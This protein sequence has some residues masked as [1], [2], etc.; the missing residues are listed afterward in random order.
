M[1]GEGTISLTP[2]LSL[3]RALL[4]PDVKCNLLSVGKL[5]DTLYC[6][7]HFYRIVTTYCYF[8][9]IQTQKIIGRGKRI[10]GLY[11]LT[12]E[13]TVVSGSNNHQALSA[14]VDDRH[15]IWLWHRRLGHP[16]FSYMKH[17]FP[18]LF[19]TCSD[20]EFKCETCVMAKS[21]RA[22]FPISDSKATLPFDLIHSDV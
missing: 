4:V 16:S 17:L 12:M 22:S 8:Q 18:S 1:K 2:T 3:V 7:A 21:H 11:I 20:S 5:L 10:G 19:R 15:Q 14:K 13:D 6:S 9:D